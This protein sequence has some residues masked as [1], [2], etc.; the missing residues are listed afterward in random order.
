MLLS[1][2]I[3]NFILIDFV[4]LDF[5]KGFY[6]ITGETGAGKSVLLDALLFVLGEKFDL[7]PVKSGTDMA[8]VT[9]EFS[10]T[11]NLTSLLAEHGIET[12][13]MLI[14]K[15]QQYHGGKK[16]FFIND[17]PVT[18]KL[19]SVVADELLEMHGQH[20]HS[21]LLDQSKH[22]DII[23]QFGDLSSA[24]S[25][26]SQKFSEWQKLERDI[27]EL[28]NNRDSVLREID[29]LSFAVKELTDKVPK[30]GEETELANLR[31]ELQNS[32]KDRELLQN[33]SNTMDRSNILSNIGSLQRLIERH[34]KSESFKNVLENLISAYSYMEEAEN[35]VAKL[36]QNSEIGDLDSV[37]TR[38][39]EIRALARKYNIVADELPAY[40][41]KSKLELETLESR[42]ENLEDLQAQMVALKNAYIDASSML[43]DMRKEAAKLLETRIQEELV[44]L[45]MAGCKWMVEFT[46]KDEKNFT[47]N[48]IDIVRFTA[49]TNPG[50]PS[51]PIDKI[52]SG[53]E[54][55]RLMLA[56]KVALFDKFS[57]PTIIFDEIDTGIGGSVADA[58][59]DR[60]KALS[61][62]AQVIVITHQP[63]VVAKSD[64][65]IL[66]EKK[67][68]DGNTASSARIL[69]V[70][71][72]KGEIARMLSGKSITTG[73]IAAAEELM[74]G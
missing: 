59:G 21:I 46:R 2:Q 4:S 39:F 27:L 44:P 70:E 31:I 40:Y 43:S 63:Q 60:L 15:R 49:A 14:I 11:P 23:D 36:T 9:A 16:K 38:L 52:A 65:H 6:V 33:V 28:Q 58:I 74:G 45:R 55:A 20:S 68:T 13:E 61:Q 48:G 69:D 66:V 10:S 37:E 72:K 17:E 22:I 32:S 50:M 24:V 8:S 25:D 42:I 1:L 3:K 71:G 64:F 67:S 35:E 19:L 56:V 7:D 47:S 41:E 12:L 34:S 26:V 18:A 5:Q 51:G 62:V 53:G 54:L 30:I 73:A 29:F 57:K